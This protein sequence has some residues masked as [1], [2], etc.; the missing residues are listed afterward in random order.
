MGQPVASPHH[1]PGHRGLHPRA[2]RVAQGPGARPWACPAVTLVLVTRSWSLPSTAG[3]RGHRSGQGSQS[4]SRAPDRKG[5]GRGHRRW[6]HSVWAAAQAWPCI[7][8]MPPRF[9]HALQR[10]HHHTGGQGGARR[11][12]P[13]GHPWRSRAQE[14]V[15]SKSSLRSVETHPLETRGPLRPG[16]SLLRPPG[17]P[18][19]H[20]AFLIRSWDQMPTGL[21][22]CQDP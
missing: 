10:P 6:W 14:Q 11:L 3:S 19:G 21:R 2:G 4:P 15:R 12:V 18:E 5:S 22:A 1:H 17:Q 16:H 13:R 9:L 7:R 20:S 8:P